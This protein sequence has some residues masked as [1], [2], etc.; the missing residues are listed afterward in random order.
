V[1]TG[2]TIVAS[3]DV[4]ATTKRKACASPSTPWTDG[5]TTNNFQRDWTP[6]LL[7]EPGT[8]YDRASLNIDTVSSDTNQQ[9]IQPQLSSILFLAECVQYTTGVV[10]AVG[11][12]WQLKDQQD[13]GNLNLF[14][15]NAIVKL[16]E[17]QT[18]PGKY[19]GW[20]EWDPRN[21][22][23]LISYQFIP[24]GDTEPSVRKL[25][26]WAG[27]TDPIVISTSM[28][29]QLRF[30]IGIGPAG[31]VL[32][33]DCPISYATGPGGAGTL[34][35]IL[36]PLIGTIASWFPVAF[37]LGYPQLWTARFCNGYLFFLFQAGVAIRLATYSV[38]V[39][40]VTVTATA[41]MVFVFAY[42]VAESII[43]YRC[44]LTVMTLTDG[45]KI[46]AGY[47]GGEWFVVSL[48]YDGVIRYADFE[49]KSCADAATQLAVVTNSIVYVDEFRSL[50]LRN[51]RGLGRGDA[52]RD[53]DVIFGSTERHISEVYRTSVQVKG[54]LSSGGTIDVV[55]GE[56]GD[57]ARRMEIDSPL[58]S[59]NGMA[60]ATG[61]ATLQF[62]S[63]IR[64]E[65]ECVVPC[66]ETPL[67]FGDRVTVGEKAYVVYKG[68]I[69]LESEEQQLTLLEV[70]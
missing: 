20:I 41:T 68:E 46:I 59:T 60:V 8:I 24:D 35:L 42:T 23:V 27:P 32:F 49:N 45:R 28:S 58:V 7:A 21:G 50:A 52:L 53:L 62:V 44:Y 10:G 16:I 14:K 56:T 55:V 47:A 25:M 4:A 18:V 38:E 2:T 19:Q 67:R 29:G 64:S 51:R 69:D 70:V 57:S 6:Y 63:V 11:D 65:R 15:N 34:Y 61:I 5:A 48:R 33:Y 26:Y 22:V 40:G 36:A 37:N 17:D 54:K 12:V 39:A 13:V 66:D 1:P 31:A 3:Y 43:S 9:H 30:A